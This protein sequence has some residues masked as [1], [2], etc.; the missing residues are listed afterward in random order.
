[1]T[2]FWFGQA[3]ISEKT[4]R[5]TVNL[6]SDPRS[7]FLAACQNFVVIQPVVRTIWMN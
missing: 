3:S 4:V 7:A 6:L 5:N 2:V 1:V